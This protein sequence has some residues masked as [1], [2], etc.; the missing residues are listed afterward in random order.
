[1]KNT[2]LKLVFCLPLSLV[3]LTIAVFGQTSASLSGTVHD[4]E[5]AAITTATVKTI[6]TKTGQKFETITAGDGNF[7]FPALQ[8]GNYTIEIALAGFRRVVKTGVILNV[9]EK[10]TIGILTLEVSGVSAA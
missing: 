10:R 3:L 9:A 4:H 1:M 2:F 8:A 5:G 6:N 7:S